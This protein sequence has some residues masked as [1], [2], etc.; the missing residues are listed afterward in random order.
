MHFLPNP[1]AIPGLFDTGKQGANIMCAFTDLGGADNDVV[2]VEGK[3]EWDVE[4]FANREEIV[5]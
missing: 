5:G 2:I 3:A 1:F 4:F